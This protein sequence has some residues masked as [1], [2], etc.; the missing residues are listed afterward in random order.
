MRAHFFHAS[1]SIGVAMAMMALAGCASHVS[2]QP[3][4]SSGSSI[5]TL[6]SSWQ[7]DTG[8][9]LRLADLRG[10]PRVIA[11]F[12]TSCEGTCSLT[13]EHLKRIEASL[14]VDLRSGAS[15]VL[16]SLDP[17]RDTPATLAKF[18][19]ENQLAS[20]RWLLLRGDP[21]PTADLATALKVQYAKDPARR[22]R[23]ASQIT[24]LDDAGRIILQQTGT[25]PDLSA[26][27][28]ALATAATK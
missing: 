2:P 23:H 8:G 28:D 7:T 4:P 12:F 17:V 24:V 6:D 22:I 3:A 18:R 13:V 25:R 26:T 1:G 5:Y 9:T 19:S 10:H 20:D 11:M 15:F 21:A 14:P 16:V 27:I